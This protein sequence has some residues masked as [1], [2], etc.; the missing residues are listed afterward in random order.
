[1]KRFTLLLLLA[2]FALCLPSET[3]GQSNEIGRWAASAG[4]V[5]TGDGD[6]PY[7]GAMGF[8]LAAWRVLGRSAD[9]GVRISSLSFESEG[10][11]FAEAP[12]LRPGDGTVAV[13]DVALRWYP[14]GSDGVVFPFVGISAGF[15][16]A[17]SFDADRLVIDDLGIVLDSDWELD[18]VGYGAEVGFRYDFAGGQWFVEGAA[19]YFT[20]SGESVG[21][22]EVVP[23]IT[24]TRIVD[25]NLDSLRFALHVGRYF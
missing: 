15:V 2:C 5:Q 16:F 25:A 21:I 4:L 9:L 22:I 23:A 10:L 14:L 3:V 1:M 6:E 17:D 11:E 12:S 20:L 18:S 19:R 8:E 24:R 7:T 13:A